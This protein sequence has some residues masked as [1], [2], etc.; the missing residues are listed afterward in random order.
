MK[1]GLAMGVTIGGNAAKS[2]NNTNL[3]VIMRLGLSQKI[4][5]HSLTDWTRKMETDR[6]NIQKVFVITV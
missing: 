1:N 4:G 6:N 2:G 5:L 3:L